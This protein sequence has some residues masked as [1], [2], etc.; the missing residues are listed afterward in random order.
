M[1]DKIVI[2]CIVDNCVFG[3]LEEK[4][5]SRQM[6][7]RYHFAFFFIQYPTIN[8]IECVFSLFDEKTMIIISHRLSLVHYWDM[9]ISNS[10]KH[11]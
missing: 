7:K 6:L 2:N 9:Q 11:D 5:L 1:S 4:M 3:L 8:M 10:E